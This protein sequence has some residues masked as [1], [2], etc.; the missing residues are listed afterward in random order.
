MPASV[1]FC[2]AIPA[3]VEQYNRYPPNRMYWSWVTSLN[4]LCHIG[5][6]HWGAKKSNIHTHHSG[7]HYSCLRHL[8]C[9]SSTYLVTSEQN[10]WNSYRLGWQKRV[11]KICVSL[12]M[13]TIPVVIDKN[14]WNF[15][16]GLRILTWVWRTFFS[17]SCWLFCKGCFVG[18]CCNGSK[19][20]RSALCKNN[21]WLALHCHTITFK[22]DVMEG[23]LYE[24]KLGQTDFTESKYW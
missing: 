2:P 10:V 17:C 3:S 7:I 18:V 24:L 15:E 20:C 21:K 19:N 11:E 23:A 4:N 8:L 14:M 6:I 16:A 9:K 12:P 13:F 22:C 5:T 1:F